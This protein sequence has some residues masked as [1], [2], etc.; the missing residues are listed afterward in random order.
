[1]NHRHTQARCT[2]R[3]E[4]PGDQSPGY[5]KTPHEWGSEAGFIRRPRWGATAGLSSS[6]VSPVSYGLAAPL[7]RLPLLCWSLALLLLVNAATVDAQVR[8]VYDES[9]RLVQ[10]IGL[11]GKSTRYR[12]DAAGNIISMVQDLT[13]ALV[14]SEFTPNRGPIGTTVTISGS[15]F[16]TT[17]SANIVKFNGV[18]ATVSAATATRL[19]TKVPTGATTGLIRVTVGAK[20]ATSAIPFTITTAPDNGIPVITS[21]TPRIGFPGAPVSITGNNFST[22]PTNNFVFFNRTLATVGA[23]TLTTINTKVPTEAT[24]GPIKVRTATG[25]AISTTD[26]FVVPPGY[27]AGN[28]SV[29]QRIAVNGPALAINTG[30]AGKIAMVLFEGTQGQYLGLWVGPA[31][32]T[33]GGSVKL[34]IKTPSGTNLFPQDESFSLASS[35]DLPRLPETGTYTIL[36]VPSASAVVNAT[37][38]LSTDSAGVLT[39]NGA[40]TAVNLPVGRNGRY[41]FTVPAP[42]QRLSLGFTNMATNPTNESVDIWVYRPDGTTELSECRIT[43]Y[44]SSGG[45]SCDLKDSSSNDGLLPPGTYTVWVDNGEWI[46]TFNL[47]LSADVAGALALNTAKG[48]TTARVGQNASYT[49]NG[50]VGQ[51]LSLALSGDTFPGT[52]YVYVY[53]PDGTQLGGSEYLYYSSGTGDV[54]T[55]N[56]TTLPVPGP[57]AVFI[58]PSGLATGTIST[59]LWADAVGTVAIDGPAT[60]VSLPLGRDGRYR[61]TVPAPGKH[62][63]LGFTNMA[64]DPTNES[65]YIEAYKPDGTRLNE[66][67]ITVYQGSGGGSCDLKDSSSNDGF[68]PPGIYTVWV[69]ND[70]WRVTT[71]NLLLS[72]DKVATLT[73]NSATPTPITTSRVGQNAH[74]TFNNAV[75]GRNLRLVFSGNTFPT[76]TYVYV[77]GPDG[78]YVTYTSL[79]SSTLNLNALPVGTYKVAIIPDD[80]ATGTVSTRLITQ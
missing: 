11:D 16:S 5:A 50:T 17:V 18:T 3:E 1:M 32:I 49:F 36:I 13:G 79:S 28:V 70:E 66:C 29:A 48:F 75:A 73:L 58:T 62:L 72:A 12:Y 77:Y 9:G 27:T 40:A 55:L 23:T 71:L 35:F 60:V 21:F 45:G 47:W 37:L 15:G 31:T 67:R 44:Q 57:Y 54:G 2:T 61:F 38:T 33:G 68:L 64:T 4:H 43:V 76:N 22:T 24:S 20:V 42:G 8:Y 80:L 74:Y 52:T 65:V 19:T 78:N 30:T 34:F 69:D 7:S 41:T 59:T 53:K 10:V 39:A 63:G 6:A 51:N 14:I 25:T 26:F 56:L 46:S